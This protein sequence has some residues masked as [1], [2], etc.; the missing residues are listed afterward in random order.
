MCR[1]G[2]RA[3]VLRKGGAG[4]KSKLLLRWRLTRA[5]FQDYNQVVLSHIVRVYL[6]FQSFRNHKLT[7]LVILL[8]CLNL[9][10]KILSNLIETDL[11]S[12]FKL[13]ALMKLK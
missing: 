1:F 3:N 9:G 6:V 2:Q 4:H 11:Y 13:R 8:L 5:R 7:G 12:S 10:Y